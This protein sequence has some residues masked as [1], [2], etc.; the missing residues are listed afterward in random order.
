MFYN[1]KK[2]LLE[3]FYK[4]NV[5]EMPQIESISLAFYTKEVNDI[6]IKSSVLFLISGIKPQVLYR[7]LSKK[8]RKNSKE[9]LGCKVVLQKKE[10][11]NFFYYLVF[12][13]SAQN[14]N[15]LFKKPK[16]NKLLNTF[17]FK[18]PDIFIFPELN[19]EVDKFYG[20]KDLNVSIQFKNK[21]GINYFFN[22]FNLIKA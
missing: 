18:I 21:F 8:Q 20:I 5:F 22:L 7:N 19:K 6:V 15:M 2:L 12:I 3:K 1:R 9:Y 16:E 14:V 4:K 11:L 17:S 13:V 10:A